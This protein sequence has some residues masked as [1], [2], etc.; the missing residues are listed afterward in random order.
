MGVVPI[1]STSYSY[2]DT[3]TVLDNTGLLA[4]TSYYFDGWNTQADG[5]GTRYIANN[6]FSIIENTNLYAQWKP[7]TDP[8]PG[9]AE[10]E[11]EEPTTEKPEGKSPENNTSKMTPTRIKKPST[12]A[13]NNKESMSPTSP[14]TGDITQITIIDSVMLLSGIGLFILIRKTRYNN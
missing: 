3:V 5:Q 6:S 10:P 4:K 8:P 9:T 14:H 12:T 1:D 11:T 2:H 13:V 7:V